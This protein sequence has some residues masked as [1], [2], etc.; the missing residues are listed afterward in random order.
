MGSEEPL[1]HVLGHSRG[2]LATKIHM[3]CCFE[4]GITSVSKDVREQGNQ[5]TVIPTVT[6]E[7]EAKTMSNN[8]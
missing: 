3:V 6:R 7:I 4:S 5:V 1:D 2:G 8:R